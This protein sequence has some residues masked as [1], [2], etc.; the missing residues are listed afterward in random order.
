MKNT[1]SMRT[2][3]GV[4]NATVS[5]L[6]ITQLSMM[7]YVQ[8]KTISDNK[9]EFATTIGAAVIDKIDRNLFERYGDVQAFA[10][11]EPA[12]SS[13]PKRITDFMNDMMTTYAPIYDVMMVVNLEG[14]VIAVNTVDKAGK[15][16]DTAALLGKDYSR[17]AWFKDSVSGKVEPGTSWVGDLSYDADIGLI[18]NTDGAVMNFSA[19]IRDKE[20]GKIIAV[21]SNRMSWK[22]VV[23]AITHEELAKLDGFKEGKVQAAMFNQDGLYLMHPLAEYVLKEKEEEISFLKEQ[24]KNGAVLHTENFDIPGLRGEFYEVNVLSKGYSI[25]PGKG[26]IFRTW[27][28][29]ED[30]HVSLAWWQ[31]IMGLVLQAGG[32]VVG[33]FLIRKLARSLEH[34]MESL[35]GESSQVRHTAGEITVG[36]QNLASA[37]TE[38]AS[39]LQETASS[40]EEMNAMVKKSADNAARSREVAQQ[41]SVAANRGKESVEQMMTAITEINTSNDRIMRQV[42][43]SNRQITEIVK[44]ITEIG[45]KTKVINDIVFQTK[46][47]SFNASVEAARAG[48]HGKGFAVVAEEVGNLAQMSGNAAKEIADMLNGSIQKVESIVQDTKSRVEKLISEGKQKVESGT[49]VARQC[50]EIL[51]E[52][53]RNVGDVNHMI[54][55]ISTA[56][57]E[58]STGINEITKAMNQ[59]D[60]VTHQNASV[61]QQAANSAQGL[62]LQSESMGELLESLRIV[63]QGHGGGDE[64]SHSPVAPTLS[65]KSSAPA[66]KKEVWSDAE[67]KVSMKSFK[68]EEGHSAPPPVKKAVGSEVVPSDDDPRFKDL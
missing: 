10:L 46:L 59:L 5:L 53:V 26:W 54:S 25:Y 28:T 65:T 41:S 30:P 63:V 50:G 67:T 13:N 16:L 55:E 18:A 9:K 2:K 64:P 45:N 8:I 27:V 29:T 3:L 40:V 62:V 61:S 4:L 66:P 34:V 37:T 36:S 17:E 23:I 38:Q 6:A 31:V 39:A 15:P 35:L 21:W 32:W 58:Q 33:Y 48:E 14:K 60:Q 1:W 56:T 51:E 68:K 57:Q 22:D 42:E 43:D 49:Q 12:R 20:T 11:S 7:A 52:V 44:V 47:L 19:P 24:V